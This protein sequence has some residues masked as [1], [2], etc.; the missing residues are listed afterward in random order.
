MGVHLFGAVPLPAPTNFARCKT[1]EDKQHSF[2]PSVINTLKMNFY[3]D[4]Y[5][6]SLPSEADAIQHVDS[7]RVLLSRGGFKIIK[8]ISSSCNVLETFPELERSEDIKNIDAR[9]DE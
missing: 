6:K 7:L 4:D 8:W 2:P 1:T 3:V 5:L 9:K